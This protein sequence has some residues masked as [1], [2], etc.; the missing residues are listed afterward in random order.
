MGVRSWIAR[1]NNGR[2]QRWDWA[3]CV[4]F[5]SPGRQGGIGLFVRDPRVFVIQLLR[6]FGEPPGW[7]SCPM[8]EMVLGFCWLLGLRACD[9]SSHLFFSHTSISFF[10]PDA[11][12]QQ[13]KKL[14]FDAACMYSQYEINPIPSHPIP[15]KSPPSSYLS[16]AYLTS[17]HHVG[18][19]CGL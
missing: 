7:E 4:R 18:A 16:E 3:I 9:F 15:F 2:K 19:T 5:K 6:W 14:G 11:G 8:L 17:S 10:F 12:D 1:E 13:N